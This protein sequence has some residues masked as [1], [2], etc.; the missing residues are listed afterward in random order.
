MVTIIPAE[1]LVVGS[2]SI[3]RRH[4][5]NLLDLGVHQVLVVT[6][7]DVSGVPVFS[8]SRVRVVSEL[9]ENCPRAAIVASETAKHVSMA[10]N[11]VAAG[12]HVLIEKPVDTTIS[13]ETI[14]LTEEA[15]RQRVLV[16]VGYNLRFLGAIRRIREVLEEASIGRPLFSRIEVGQWLPDW[17]PDRDYREAYSA[18]TA[19]GG[20][21][22]LDL[23]HELDYMRLL[24]GMPTS[25]HTTQMTS[26][27][28]DVDANDVFEGVYS[29]VGG[30]LSSVHLDYIERPPRRRIRIVGSEGSIECDL[31]AEHLRIESPAGTSSTSAHELFDV[32][33]TY[34]HEIEAFFDE[35]AGRPAGLATLQD[36]LDV[37]RLLNDSDGG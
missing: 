12:A 36:G 27:L 7:R 13:S 30:M 34:V 5:S 37:L 19:R 17:R 25:W 15:D 1:V 21:V 24:F 8:D 14:S 23:S 20:G 11:L 33:G 9:P 29:F 3:A 4:V 18:S 26:G 22:A 31:I 35:I 28:L 10:R 2:G 32:Q 6:A 16:R